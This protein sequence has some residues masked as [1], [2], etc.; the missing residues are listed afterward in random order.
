MQNKIPHF[1]KTYPARALAR[2]NDGQPGTILL[3]RGWKRLT[4]LT[5]GWRLAAGL[6]LV[7]NRKVVWEEG[8]RE[9]PPY[10]DSAPLASGRVTDAHS[11]E[12]AAIKTR[13]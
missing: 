9:T 2:K 10:P 4:D 6:R 1:P 11:C 8:S 13:G 5:Q 3:W 12:S 7:G